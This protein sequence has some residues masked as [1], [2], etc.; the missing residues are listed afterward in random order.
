MK[1]GGE[2]RPFPLEGDTPVT[3]QCLGSTF[4]TGGLEPTHIPDLPSIPTS[5]IHS[6]YPRPGT[7]GCFL[8]QEAWLAQARPLSA[9]VDAWPLASLRPGLP[10]LGLSSLS[11]A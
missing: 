3:P 9:A 10:R 8:Q 7:Q 1:G 4:W 5:S 6:L 2:E 11:E